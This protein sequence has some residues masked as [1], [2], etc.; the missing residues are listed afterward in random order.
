[1]LTTGTT[2]ARRDVLGGQ[3]WAAAP[4]RVL[5]DDGTGLIPD[6]LEV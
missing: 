3:V 1:M 4:H 5:R 2:V 6:V